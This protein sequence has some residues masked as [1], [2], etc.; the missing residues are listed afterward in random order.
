MEPEGE[1]DAV[2]GAVG[3]AEALPE[4]EAAFG[5][6]A[7]TP[8]LPLLQA[9]P[10]PESDAPEDTEGAPGETVGGTTVPVGEPL[11]AP[12][13]AVGGTV[14]CGEVLAGGE[15]ASL[16]EA[17][18]QGAPLGVGAGVGEPVGEGGGE[19]DAGAPL[20]EGGAVAGAE[21]EAGGVCGAVALPPV[22]E[23]EG[24][25][26]G[27][28]EG[29][30]AA[31]PEGAGVA[32]DEG[33]GAPLPDGPPLR[34]ALT[35]PEALP[36]RRAERLSEELRAGER[37]DDGVRGEEADAEAQGGGEGERS[38]EPDAEAEGVPRCEAEAEPPA[39]APLDG[40]AHALPLPPC[41]DAEVLA[42]GDAA[43]EGGGVGVA[44]ADVEG[45]SGEVLDEPLRAREGEALPLPAGVG[46]AAPSEAL[47]DADAVAHAVAPRGDA[48]ALC[49]AQDVGAP[50]R[51]PPSLGLPPP[52][53]SRDEALPEGEG[54]GDADSR[55]LRELLLLSRGEALGAP[56]L[57]V[58][59]AGEALPERLSARVAGALPVPPPAGEPLAPPT[60]G[61][62]VAQGAAEAEGAGGDALAEAVL[63]PALPLALPLGVA[64]RVSV[65]VAEKEMPTAEGGAVS[66]G[67]PPLP[68]G[69]SVASG[70]AE[71]PAEAVSSADSV[72]EGEGM[73][74]KA[75]AETE[76]QPLG[77]ALGESQD[78]VGAGEAEGEPEGV[79]V[80]EVAAEGESTG[81]ALR[82]AAGEP[83]EER[84]PVAVRD[85]PPERLAAAAEGEGDR[86]A[87][88]GEG[89][90]DAVTRG[91]AVG[92]A[93][94]S[95]GAAEGAPLGVAAPPVGDGGPLPVAGVVGCGVPVAS[96]GEALPVGEPPSPPAVA[97][98][99]LLADAVAQ[100]DA[101]AGGD[102]EAAREARPLGE[103]GGER[104]FEEEA[105]GSGGVAVAVRE[106]AR[107]GGAEA[108][109]GDGDDVGEPE[110][111]AEPPPRGPVLG[112]PVPLAHFVGP[113][114]EGE[115]S[116]EGDAL[117]EG[118]PAAT[119]PVAVPLALRAPQ[120]EG[121]PVP[122]PLADGVAGTAEGVRVPPEAHAE[123]VCEALDEG[124]GGAGEGEALGLPPPPP[125]G[126]APVPVTVPDCDALPQ[127]LSR[128]DAE[129]EGEREGEGEAL[130]ECVPLGEAPPP[131]ALRAAVGDASEAEGAPDGEVVAE[132]ASEGVPP[133]EREALPLPRAPPPPELP[134]AP[135][136]GVP[137][138]LP[139]GDPLLL[140]DAP[141][142][143]VSVGVSEGAP[144]RETVA[145]R[146]REALSD[147]LA[148][149]E[150]E[151][152]A[153]D[154]ALELRHSVGEALLEGG[155]ELL[156][157]VEP[158][159]EAQ[160]VTFTVT[161]PRGVTEGHH[162]ALGEPL[163]D[164]VPRPVG[165]TVGE[166]RAE[167]VP[168]A[169]GEGVGEAPPVR[170]A[171]PLREA[172][173]MEER[174]GGAQRVA[175]GD[176]ETVA[177]A[178]AQREAPGERLPRGL[179]E[180]L[181]ELL[182]LP[183]TRPLRD[184]DCVLEVEGEPVAA[185]EGEGEPE[186]LAQLLSEPLLEGASLA[187]SAL[188]EPVREGAPERVKEALPE[189]E[190]DGCEEALG[191]ELTL[192][193][194]DAPTE[195][196]R[197]Y[198]AV[199]VSVAV[200]GAVG[201]LDIL[202]DA[203]L[204]K[205][206]EPVA[207]ELWLGDG[208]KEG[209][210]VS[211]LEREGDAE[212]VGQPVARRVPLSVAV[213][214]ALVEGVVEGAREADAEG[215]REALPR[216]ERD[217]EGDSE[218]LRDGA[219]LPVGPPG[220]ALC[221]SLAQPEGEAL[222]PPR[223]GEAL[224]Q[225]DAL[226]EPLAQEDAERLAR[227]ELDS[228]LLAV[229]VVEA[230]SAP[231]ALPKGDGDG[232][233]AP[234]PVGSPREAVPQGDRVPLRDGVMV[235]LPV[236]GSEL[237][238]DTDAEG[239]G[240]AL[241]D[242]D[243]ERHAEG[244]AEELTLHERVGS[245]LLLAEGNDVGDG[246]GGEEPEVKLEALPVRDSLAQGVGDPE[247][248]ALPLGVP[249]SQRDALP[250]PRLAD[251]LPLSVAPRIDAEGVAVSQK[252][253]LAR[254]V[255]EKE[256]VVEGV[257]EGDVV[258]ERHCD[259][260]G[261]AVTLSKREGVGAA[262]GVRGAERDRASEGDVVAEA[263][264]PAGGLEAL[265]V[266][267]D[268]PAPRLAVHDAL[269][270]AEGEAPPD[271]DGDTDAQGVGEAPAL[272]Q[273]E[274]V[275]APLNE[276]LRS[277]VRV[278]VGTPLCD[279]LPRVVTEGQRVAEGVGDGDTERRADTESEGDAE[280]EAP[281]ERVALPRGEALAEREAE[282]HAL[283]EIDTAAEALAEG[284]WEALTVPARVAPTVREG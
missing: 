25:A 2:D 208:E 68:L 196:E 37:E 120:K 110:G 67:A 170:D 62:G 130:G 109:S 236:S 111:E 221:E 132:S 186:A 117:G 237:L 252:L 143:A 145:E 134:D 77:E 101:E 141:L 258:P 72:E 8:P 202:E 60:V 194:R 32:P 261:V 98:P 163:P 3:D 18:P 116:A 84:L 167:P 43:C 232:E 150:G 234:L 235:A 50:L 157:E 40:V 83:L 47:C 257:G 118:V 179:A 75:V 126:R 184:A 280:A 59:G 228:E 34:E 125:G 159:A 55:A 54:A 263:L 219:G 119:V 19:G 127:R 92:G 49:D 58:G 215:V 177:L 81:E 185:A 168:G 216:G 282:G 73:E 268:V 16:R 182:P 65:G 74:G 212:A 140:P 38:G 137:E 253:S 217:A 89:D 193:E 61:V 189:G 104:L 29:D 166:P 270:H 146:Q 128:G 278:S 176:K 181:G 188:Q 190:G 175:E 266:P 276:M 246:V 207:L 14:T 99:L 48:D 238:L 272:A 102:A 165:D 262:V 241:R 169:E 213:G 164:S 121:E 249:V 154:E 46:V 260:E 95:E 41:A 158:D 171:L 35:L 197:L 251:T 274:A 57:G 113:S 259:G 71:V 206:A 85:A 10:P 174:E 151:N 192:A 114:A 198:V 265:T 204:V 187:V 229:P 211:A 214:C 223:A 254:A 269:A 69:G 256:P 112:E 23:G 173:A 153:Q 52:P 220:V 136:E 147:P 275:A 22:G 195:A 191:R 277:P 203:L 162:D 242:S 124:E 30:A 183:L 225:G 138:R 267:V 76:A 218:A 160:R 31:L 180:S 131:L 107:E 199:S 53:R 205:D 45:A 39:G 284:V 105:L 79:P 264:P 100:G 108:V 245:A 178:L 17:L 279:A 4:E 86:E 56:P 152:E 7:V 97:L 78:A 255:S 13:V 66:E 115:G 87:P 156:P 70:D 271:G 5:G 6:E 230:D 161:L 239:E 244:D 51:V 133:G 209:V 9:V 135:A 82:E 226:K 12:G 42:V 91:D 273:D 233:R 63:P 33:E 227:G 20:G 27:G 283:M 250:A 200:A 139:L 281:T 106:G 149:P 36:L 88:P 129:A 96:G 123:A 148:A 11:S 80:G 28:A 201:S 172:E 90:S 222:P 231:E 24:G 224:P 144:M 240:G 122:L 210:G 248:L 243:A 15:G 155:A 142:V 94:V 44:A 26:E 247:R 64:L 1:S 21:A 103:G 93:R